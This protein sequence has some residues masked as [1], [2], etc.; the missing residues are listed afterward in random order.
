MAKVSITLP[1]VGER[2]MRVITS[3]YFGYKDDKPKPCVVVFVNAAHR[4]YTVQ[5][6]ESHIKESYKPSPGDEY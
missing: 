5:F 3:T 1:K 4:Y 2:L 6:T